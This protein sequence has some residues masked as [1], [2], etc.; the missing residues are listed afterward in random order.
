MHSAATPYSVARLLKNGAWLGKQGFEAR[1]FVQ[2][3]MNDIEILISL[4]TAS[5]I[6]RVR[7]KS[8]IGLLSNDLIRLVR[9]CLGW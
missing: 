1:P 6:P 8:L 5:M 2:Y 3:V 9:Q 4:C 7:Q